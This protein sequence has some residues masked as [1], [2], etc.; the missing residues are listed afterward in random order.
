SGLGGLPTNSNGVPWNG[1]YIVASGNLLADMRGS[2][3]LLLNRCTYTF[4]RRTAST[5]ATTITGSLNL[6]LN[7]YTYASYRRAAFA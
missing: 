4:Y 7:R 2:L 6:L 3:D 1:S 5:W